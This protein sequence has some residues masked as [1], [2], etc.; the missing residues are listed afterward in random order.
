MLD[1]VP[2][3]NGQILLPVSQA[4]PTIRLRGVAAAV[5]LRASDEA[6]TGWL[7]E[8]EQEACIRGRLLHE[9]GNAAVCQ[10]VVTAGTAHYPLHPALYEID[11]IAFKL[12]HDGSPQT[13]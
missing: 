1:D 7:N 9:S 8:A 2:C 13:P 10:I 5:H 6:V 11:Y 4:P 3:A 12:L